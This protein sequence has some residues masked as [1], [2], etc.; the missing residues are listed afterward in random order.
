MIVKRQR[1]FA[2]LLTLWALAMITAIVTAHVFDVRS[3]VVMTSNFRD[4]AR[5]R[6]VADAGVQLGI[7]KLMERARFGLTETSWRADGSWY[8]LD[9][10]G[11]P[12][13]I[14]I[15]AE[16]G[17]VDLNAASPRVIAALVDTLAENA[18]QHELAASF[19]IYRENPDNPPL[20]SVYQLEQVLGISLRGGDMSRRFTVYSGD[21]KIN[22]VL[23]TPEV[24]EGLP[25][26]QRDIIESYLADRDQQTDASVSNVSHRLTAAAEFVELGGSRRIRNGEFFT[27]RA[28]VGLA[29]GSRSTREAVIKLDAV[30]GVPYSVLSWRSIAAQH[31]SEDSTCG[32]VVLLSDAERLGC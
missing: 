25:G 9:V 1:G 6:V 3:E 32:W 23:S 26:L 15:A 5:A 2:L 4:A 16:S 30:D 14:S 11:V 12:V 29:S 24:L 10:D 17:K 28:R 7:L 13:S 20:T 8:V 31:A 18:L 21:P 19:R 22:P 27:I